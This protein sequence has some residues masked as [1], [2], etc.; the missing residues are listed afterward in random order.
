MTH[1]S[2]KKLS[3]SSLPLHTDYHEVKGIDDIDDIP[4]NLVQS[5][6]VLTQSEKKGDPGFVCVKGIPCVDCPTD[7]SPL[8]VER[9]RI[10]GPYAKMVP[11]PA[12]AVILWLGTT[13]H[14]NCKAGHTLQM[15]EK[16]DLT[17]ISMK[18]ATREQIVTSLNTAGYCVIVDV[19][20]QETID[21]YIGGMTSDILSAQV[22]EGASPKGQAGCA[23]WKGLGLPCTQNAQVRRL[24]PAVHEI[25][26]MI[27]GTP[28]LT[29]SADSFA[30]QYASVDGNYVVSPETILRAVQFICWAPAALLDEKTAKAK[31]KSF[32][33][34]QSS[35]HNP[36]KVQ[37]TVS[38]RHMS[39]RHGQWATV[40]FQGTLQETRN[41]LMGQ[42]A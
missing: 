36:L 2:F 17:H 37:G 22:V 5:Q 23:I 19:I 3:K 14:A 24:T 35:C 28:E 10:F 16:S 21:E 29:V 40:P 18:N 38:G 30:A 13:I 20:N 42:W 41:A 31:I 15:H 12:G 4:G 11:A 6:L 33:K 39:D 32:E 34:G 26:Q 25:F 1:S 8:S 7:Y 9:L 27:Y